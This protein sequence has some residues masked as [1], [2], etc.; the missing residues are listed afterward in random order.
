[1]AKKKIDWGVPADWQREAAYAYTKDLT[2][3]QWCWE[4]MR[5]RDDYRRA[6]TAAKPIPVQPLKIPARATSAMIKAI[7]EGH[8]WARRVRKT[9]D[10]RFLFDPRRPAIELDHFA[11]QLMPK[12]NAKA[13]VRLPLDDLDL[14]ADIA[15][16]LQAIKVRALAL[17][18]KVPKV[19]KERKHKQRAHIWQRYLRVLDAR[20]SGATFRVIGEKIHGAVDYHQAA[21]Y[22][23]QDHDSATKLQSK[24]P[25]T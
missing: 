17:Q 6:W 19:R 12:P 14:L 23:K 13:R 15:P 1:M 11:L 25:P 10:G 22:A 8:R 5:R 21:T 16:Q 18:K 4:F 9:A 7:K 24:E 2:H 3:E 20:A